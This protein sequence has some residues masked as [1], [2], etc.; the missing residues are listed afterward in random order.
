[1]DAVRRH[2]FSAR[3]LPGH[4]L[5]AVARHFGLAGPAREYVPG[6]RI[7]EVFLADPERV[8]RYAKDDVVDPAVAGGWSPVPVPPPTYTLKPKAPARRV[9]A[10]VVPQ[11]EPATAPVTFDLDEIL[12]RRIASGA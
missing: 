2:D 10:A 7:H 9:S 12:E 6:A 8:R 3:D 4:G 11:P 1:M 5:K